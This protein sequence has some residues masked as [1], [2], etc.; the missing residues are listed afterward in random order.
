MCPRDRRCE[1][2]CGIGQAGDGTVT[3]GSLEKYIT[4]TAWEEGWVEPMRPVRERPQ[5]VGIIGAG[6][7]GLAAAEPLRRKGYQVPVYDRYARV[8]GLM[9]YGIPHFKLETEVL[10]RHAE[11]L[12]SGRVTFHP[13]Y[14]V[15][16]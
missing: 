8:G 10:C 9:V 7:G 5:S 15:T 11:L 2:N 6:P 16:R 13:Q 3:T 1:G 12:A 14:T 4:D